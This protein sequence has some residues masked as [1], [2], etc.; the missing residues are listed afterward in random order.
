MPRAEMGM[1]FMHFPKDSQELLHLSKPSA[2]ELASAKHQDF[3]DKVL[4]TGMLPWAQRQERARARKSCLEQC[5]LVT[6]PSCRPRHK[7]DETDEGTYRPAYVRHR[8]LFVQ[9]RHL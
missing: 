7:A 2:T 1:H 9:M 6:A 5:K 4:P 8:V 3:T